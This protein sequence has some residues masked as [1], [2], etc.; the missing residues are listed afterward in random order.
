MSTPTTTDAGTSPSTDGRKIGDV[1]LD[2]Q[3]ISLAFGGVKGK[4]DYE[5]L[6]IRRF[7][8]R[9]SLS[10]FRMNPHFPV[11]SLTAMRPIPAAPLSGSVKAGAPNR[12]SANSRP[13]CAHAARPAG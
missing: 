9:Y 7:V 11:N 5:M 3:G 12:A 8:A 10:A 2:V 4:M 1:I 13:A 6:E